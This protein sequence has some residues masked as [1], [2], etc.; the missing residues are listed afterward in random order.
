MMVKGV[1]FIDNWCLGVLLSELAGSSLLL[2][3]SPVSE[4][5]CWSRHREID[6]VVEGSFV[7]AP[8]AWCM[9]CGTLRREDGVLLAGG[10]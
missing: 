3:I 7:L 1:L 4:F 8:G 9:R 2:N 5:H 10:I 6:L